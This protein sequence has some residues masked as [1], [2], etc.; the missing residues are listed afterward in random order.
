MTIQ[1]SYLN[2]IASKFE[3]DI[4]NVFI[5]NSIVINSFDLEQVTTNLYEVKFTV[6]A[7]QTTQID[8]IKLRKSDNS[9]VVENDVDIPI[10]ETEV[11]IR[12]NITVS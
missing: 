10:T 6:L 3:T 4:N 2:E 11:E 9:V 12:H 5:N 7:A 1:A 8:N